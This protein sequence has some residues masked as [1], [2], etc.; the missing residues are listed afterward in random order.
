MRVSNFWSNNNIDY[1]TNSDGNKTLS[2]QEYLNKIRSY[3]IGII[4]L[5][6]SDTWKIQQT[7]AI[8]FISSIGNDK[9]HVLHWKSDTIEIMVKQMKSMKEL[10]D[11]FKNR[12]NNLESIKSSKFAFDYVH[13]LY[14]KINLN[15]DGSYIDSP[16]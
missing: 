8:N 2:V 15:H 12:Y 10:L 13:L 14:Y 7:I 6:K 3:L 1:E 16:D 9:K 11:W 4:N 5:K